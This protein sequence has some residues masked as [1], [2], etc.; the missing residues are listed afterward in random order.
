MANLNNNLNIWPQPLALSKK[1]FHPLPYTSKRYSSTL[2]VQVAREVYFLL[3]Y[4]VALIFIPIISV[5]CYVLGGDGVTA[6][7]TF[8]WLDSDNAYPVTL[9]H[10]KLF[11]EAL[12]V[13]KCVR[14]NQYT[15]LLDPSIILIS[16][17]DYLANHPDAGAEYDAMAA[18]YRFFRSLIELNLNS[19]AIIN[20][21]GKLIKDVLQV[22]AT[23]EPSYVNPYNVTI[24]NETLTEI[25]VEAVKSFSNEFARFI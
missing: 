22:I 7:V 2:A 21:L 9:Q 15:I 11:L 4:F 14:I 5:T 8:N 3:A 10:H 25:R 13:L 6:Q 16:K 20:N 12:E 19:Q 17:A 24:C 23:Q 1:F 18:A